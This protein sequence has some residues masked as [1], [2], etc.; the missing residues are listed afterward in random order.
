VR[1]KKVHSR[2]CKKSKADTVT[3]KIRAGIPATIERSDI[4]R[5]VHVAWMKLFAR[6]ETKKCAIAA[7][8]WGPPNYILLDHHKLQETKDRV[9]SIKEIYKQQVKDGV[10]IAD[11]TSL[12]TDRGAMGLTMDMCL[13]QKVEENALGQLSATTKKEK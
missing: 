2:L 9:R 8:G 12:N 4:V 13:D 6:V 3:A 1:N 7:R 5:I 11:L 10:D